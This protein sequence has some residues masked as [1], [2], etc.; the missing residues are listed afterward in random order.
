MVPWSNT[1]AMLYDLFD[2][3]LG[4]DYRPAALRRPTFAIGFIWLVIVSAML[5][6]IPGAGSDVGTVARTALIALVAA[7]WWWSWWELVERVRV[8]LRSRPE[9]GAWRVIAYFAALT[10]YPLVSVGVVILVY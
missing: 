2:D 7:A 4:P 1:A 6:A 3:L 10:L 8:W 9:W 5:V